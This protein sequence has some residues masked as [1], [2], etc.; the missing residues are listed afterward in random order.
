MA[1]AWKDTVRAKTIANIEQLAADAFRNH[2]L[3]V[4][5]E[6]GLYRCWRCGTP[7]GSSVYAFRIT[8][9]PGC[10]FVTGDVGDLMI[11]RSEDM[12]AW[13]RGSINSIDYFEEKIPHSVKTKVYDEDIAQEWLKEQLENEDESY[14]SEQLEHL[15]ALQRY[16]DEEHPFK[17]ALYESGLVDGCD[18]PDFDNYDSNFL[19][20]REAIKCFLRLLSAAETPA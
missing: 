17:L 12:V 14:D 16:T 5:S 3:Q 18:F 10:M 19:W 9:I 6:N 11:E 1:V 7:D 13:C 2:E 20:C 8:T 4:K 15:D